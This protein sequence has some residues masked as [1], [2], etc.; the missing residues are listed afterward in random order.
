M[1]DTKYVDISVYQKAKAGNYYCGDSY[2]YY[3][4]D[5]FFICALADGLGS[6]ELAKESS[7]AVMHVIEA[8]P[9]MDTKQ[10]V[11]ASN[12][13]LIGKRGVVLGVLKIS[14]KD[15]YY[16]YASIGNI[17]LMTITSD[18]IKSRNIPM[19][20]YLGVY[21]RTMKEV[22]EPL[23]RGTMFALFSDGIVSRD[24]SHTLFRQK[25]VQDITYAFAEKMKQ[26]RDDDTTL[27]IIKY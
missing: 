5:D 11:Q 3:E 12:Q 21:A 25:D 18:T 14:F 26:V 2:Y 13:A 16:T 9:L 15:H 20:G 27:I 10:I 4:N 6:G 19:S 23:E 8:N 24:L 1:V 17:G 7:Q 22:R